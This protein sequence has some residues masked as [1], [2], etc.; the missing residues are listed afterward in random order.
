MYGISFNKPPECEDRDKLSLKSS[1]MS[2]NVGSVCE[3][4]LSAECFEKSSKQTFIFG[5]ILSEKMNTMYDKLYI[6]H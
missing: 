1:N 5:L 3:K 4:I 2:V 6:S